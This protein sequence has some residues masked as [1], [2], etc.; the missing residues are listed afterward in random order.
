M[1]FSIWKREGESVPDFQISTLS[2]QH[3]HLNYANNALNPV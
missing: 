1:L 2:N 3:I